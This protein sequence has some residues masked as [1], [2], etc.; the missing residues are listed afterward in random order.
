M[1]LQIHPLY[2]N[3]NIPVSSLII[4]ATD[5]NRAFLRQKKL[6]F[7]WIAC[8]IKLV[9]D[10]PEN[11]TGISGGLAVTQSIAQSATPSSASPM[12][13]KKIASSG[14]LLPVIGLG[15][16]QTF[17][18]ASAAAERAPLEAVLREFA[19]LGGK[20][21]DSS[22]MYGKSEEVAGDLAAKL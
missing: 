5:F 9:V 7:F 18:V 2:F 1:R 6:L 21:I 17:D 12:L 16:W 20:L 13:A 19:A 3:P 15:T 11:F 8:F 10:V 22:P 14:E 4:G